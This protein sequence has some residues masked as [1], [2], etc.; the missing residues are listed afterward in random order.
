MDAII[1]CLLSQRMI[2]VAS[3][4]SGFVS[5]MFLV[6]KEEG[7]TLPAFNLKRLNAFL[8]TKKFRLV[9]HQKIPT[10]LQDGNYMRSRFLPFGLVTAPQ[11]FSQLSNW[12]AAKLRSQGIRCVVYLDDFLL[13]H[14]AQTVLRDQV[15]FVMDLLGRLGWQL[16]FK[17]VPASS[18]SKVNL[19]RDYVGYA[20]SANPP[21]SKEGVG[22]CVSSSAVTDSPPLVLEVGPEHLGGTQLCKLCYIVGAP[23]PDNGTD[24]FSSSPA[25]LTS[26]R[27]P[28]LS[29]DQLR[30]SLMELE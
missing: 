30:V 13:A 11:N 18:R 4:H 14:R 27:V 20:S 9:N 12:V 10:F 16:N 2:S 5:P 22:D 6:R 25:A 1:K 24:S 26:S 28:N 8:A 17:E 15:T 21:S 23:A 7:S 29:P 19:P 3:E